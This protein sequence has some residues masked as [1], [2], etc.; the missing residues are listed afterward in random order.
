MF[1][2]RNKTP[3]LP[4]LYVSP[5]KKQPK[6][7]LLDHDQTLIRHELENKIFVDVSK[8]SGLAVSSTRNFEEVVRPVLGSSD[9]YVQAR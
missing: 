5:S 1:S 4:H 3:V 8:G 6:Q 2:V 9:L 7:F